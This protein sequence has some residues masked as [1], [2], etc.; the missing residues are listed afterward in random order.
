MISGITGERKLNLTLSIL[1]T[2]ETALSLQAA[3]WK[4][5]HCREGIALKE[6]CQGKCLCVSRAN[7][8]GE[9]WWIDTDFDRHVVLGPAP[10]TARYGHMKNWNYHRSVYEGQINSRLMLPK[11]TPPFGAELAIA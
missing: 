3:Q 11:D 10:D 7:P 4:F 5:R 8:H 1:N 2:P 9:H 6:I